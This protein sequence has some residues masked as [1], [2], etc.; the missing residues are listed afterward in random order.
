MCRR[1]PSTVCIITGWNKVAVPI[2]V[3]AIPS[4]YIND[5]YGTTS[6]WLNKGDNAWQLTAATLVGIQSMP[7]LVILY[8]SIVKKKWAVNSAF[9]ALYAFAATMLCWVFW[10]YQMSFGQQ[11]VPIW[12]KPGSALGYKHLLAQATLCTTTRTAP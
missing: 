8:G 10:A 2:P 4:A 5:G 12:G 11:L 3:S 6:E 9:I 7:G 1:I